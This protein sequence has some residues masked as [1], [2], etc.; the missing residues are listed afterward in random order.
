VHATKIGV[1][2]INRTIVPK[3]EIA[4][5][6]GDIRGIRKQFELSG[7]AISIGYNST[8]QAGSDDRFARS[9]LLYDFLSGLTG[10]DKVTVRESTMK[11]EIAPMGDHAE[12][13]FSLWLPEPPG[14]KKR[15]VAKDWLLLETRHACPRQ[16][17]TQGEDPGVT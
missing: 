3:F 9:D 10:V 13:I 5:L 16:L 6:S 17:P 12:V 7:N 1:F 2:V 14:N 15:R 4:S 11:I 8:M